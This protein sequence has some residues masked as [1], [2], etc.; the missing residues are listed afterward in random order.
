MWRPPPVASAAPTTPSTATTA[1][2]AVSWSLLR[3]SP[4][5]LSYAPTEGLRAASTPGSEPGQGRN[6]LAPAGAVAV[7]VGVCLAALEEDVQVVLPGEADAAAGR[8]RRA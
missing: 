2:R 1:T 8:Q 7:R 3:T 6:L 4:P 5:L